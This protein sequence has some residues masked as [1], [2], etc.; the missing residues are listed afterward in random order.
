VAAS[1]AVVVVLATAVTL[2]EGHRTPIEPSP[3]TD[4]SVGPLSASIRE[5]LPEGDFALEWFDVRSFSAISIGTG[6]DLTRHGYGIDFPVDHA[7]RVGEFRATGRTDLP[8]LVIV[9]RTPAA[10]FTPPPGAELIVEWDHLSTDDRARADALEAEIRSDAAVEPTTLVAVDT[11][12][13]RRALVSAGADPGDVESLHDLEGDRESYEVWL[14]PA[15]TP[16][17]L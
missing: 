9:G 6:V 16:R 2:R 8:L 15:G 14:A 1:A 13:A 17:D 11:A 4:R 10:F 7:A 5:V 3:Q 12:A